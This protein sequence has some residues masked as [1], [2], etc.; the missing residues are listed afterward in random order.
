M[1]MKRGVILNVIDQ[2]TYFC[3]WYTP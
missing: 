1:H 3:C 2:S